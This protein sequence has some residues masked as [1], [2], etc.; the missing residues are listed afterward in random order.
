MS[1][2][3]DVGVM[4]GMGE[5][6]RVHGTSGAEIKEETKEEGGLLT[7]FRSKLTYS[8]GETSEMVERVQPDSRL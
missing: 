1:V 6:I 2:E 5:G 3:T 7:R 8:K 4:G